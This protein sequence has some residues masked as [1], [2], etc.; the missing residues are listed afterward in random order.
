MKYLVLWIFILISTAS[1]AGPTVA[2]LT[3]GSLDYP[4][5]T[6]GVCQAGEPWWQLVAN[7]LGGTVKET[8]V[9]PGSTVA[10]RGQGGEGACE[11][12]FLSR[13]KRISAA[14]ILLVSGGANDSRLGVPDG[15]RHIWNEWKDAD[16][17]SFRPAIG[18]LLH[19][20]EAGHPDAHIAF[21][22]EE[23]LRKEI[24]RAVRKACAA[25]GVDLVELKGVER[26]G[27]HPTARG[28]RQIA[29]QVCLSLDPFA[30]ERE[31]LEDPNRPQLHF[32][33]PRG[34]MDDPNGLSFR[35]GEYHLFYR[36]NPDGLVSGP[37]TWGHVV[38]GDLLRWRRRPPALVPYDGG[39]IWGGCGF[40][41]ENNVSRC[42]EGAHLLYY[43]WAG[44]GV[45]RQLLASSLDGVSYSA[46]P[47][48]GIL[49]PNDSDQAPCVVRLPG[50]KAY[51]MLVY[52]TEAGSSN[53]FFR[54]YNS[55][56]LRRWT[57]VGRIVGSAH[58]EGE[59]PAWR[60]G[61]PSLAQ[62]RIEGENASAWVLMGGGPYYD[63]GRFDGTNFVADVS[64]VA[65][66]DGGTEWSAGRIFNDVPDGRMLWC[67]RAKY[68]TKGGSAAF[69]QGLS[70]ILELKLVRTPRGLRLAPAP[71]REYERLRKG[72]FVP[73]GRLSSELAELRIEATVG[74][75]ARIELDLR[76]IPL[77]FDGSTGHLRCGKA[78]VGWP[79]DDE[80]LSLRVLV[81]RVGVEVFEGGGRRLLP[82]PRVS[83]EPKRR[84]FRVVSASGVADL[85]AEGV[86]LASIHETPGE[87][88]LVRPLRHGAY[89]YPGERAEWRCR[90][91]R[92]SRLSSETKFAWRVRDAR[93]R[94]FGSG[95]LPPSVAEGRPF[96]LSLSESDVG[97]RVGTLELELVA[98]QAGGKVRHSTWFTRLTGPNPKP[99]KWVGTGD[100]SDDGWWDGDFREGDLH[101][102]CGIGVLRNGIWWPRY[103]Q[104][105]G[106]YTPFAIYENW[107]RDVARRGREDLCILSGVNPSYEDR[108]DPVAFA[109]FGEYFAARMK[110]VISHF[111]IF[112]EPGNFCW[113]E[114][115]GGKDPKHWYSRWLDLTHR[116]SDALKR[117]NPDVNVLVAVEDREYWLKKTIEDGVA[118]AHEVIS[119]HPYCH[120]QPRPEREYFFKD[121]GAELKKLALE[122]GGCTRWCVTE[123]GW[124][125]VQGNVAFFE[126]V[127]CYPKVDAA[128]QARYIIRMYLLSRIYG[129]DFACQFNFRDRGLRSNYT[130]HNF[131]MVRFDSSPK[132][133]FGATS[134]LTRFLGEASPV[135]ELSPTPEKDRIC[136]FVKNGRKILAAWAIEGEGRYEIPPEFGTISSVYDL[137]GNRLPLDEVVRGRSLVLTEDPVYLTFGDPHGM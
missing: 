14:D 10:I 134:F 71:A 58:A 104:N 99:C 109:K 87:F 77:S 45:R 91:D 128:Q 53:H 86:P 16:L 30:T 133:S 81:D 82:L 92:G 124:T 50:T 125:T 112:N 119:F 132:A 37:T 76:G 89:W 135:A 110:G 129:C 34:W 6:N 118:R 66:Y 69:S 127:G 38:S 122:H 18:K 84:D 40:V 32:T 48:A 44:K 102:A 19:D 17:Q 97:G 137:Q 56:D 59:R 52:G 85:R 94:V 42:G 78:L 123:A 29:E 60:A 83:A 96:T 4:K 105:T 43:T 95:L 46:V 70:P 72:E 115:Y 3:D 22:L 107:F 54:V 117:G 65:L 33:A 36:H 12:S 101:D 79:L 88:G 93:G 24:V 68:D 90:F 80:R 120:L 25:Y 116:L 108:I 8:D 74:R 67:A 62:F 114:A 27:E 61:C 28:M 31:L 47:N 39:S 103:D 11:T 23:G 7:R 26:S 98:S 111:D 55:T 64:R 100:F 2:V 126:R 35:N 13:A 136:C 75:D 113:P 130:E 9:D 73:I 15:D 49:S 131:G 51:A 57:E 121:G 21:V 41:D 63:I 106:T 20:L 5:T 1:V